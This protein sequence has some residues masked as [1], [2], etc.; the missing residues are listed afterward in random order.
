MDAKFGDLRGVV[1][2]LTSMHPAWQS[3]TVA[4]PSEPLRQE[5]HRHREKDD[6]EQAELDLNSASLFQAAIYGLCNQ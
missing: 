2:V 6:A 5:R 3:A 4:A 1:S